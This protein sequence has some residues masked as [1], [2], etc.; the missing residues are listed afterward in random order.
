ML[1]LAESLP[2]AESNFPAFL[3]TPQSKRAVRA[4]PWGTLSSSTDH[5]S[6]LAA[7]FESRQHLAGMSFAMPCTAH[8]IRQPPAHTRP[9][10][11]PQRPRTDTR[12]GRHLRGKASQKGNNPSTAHLA[13]CLFFKNY[14]Q[15]ILHQKPTCLKRCGQ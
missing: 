5:M 15:M 12:C 10:V 14:L 4:F 11:H 1:S 6:P 3:R 9:A 8:S 13:A 2:L 7:C